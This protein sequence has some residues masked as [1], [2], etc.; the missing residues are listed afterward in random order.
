LAASLAIEFIRAS[1]VSPVTQALIDGLDHLAFAENADEDVEGWA[2][3]DWMV[4]GRIDGELV[5]QLGLLKRVIQV[6]GV[7]LVVGGVGGVATAPAWQ[8][9]GLST[10]LLRASGEF[11]QNELSVPFGLL[12]CGVEMQ[13]FYGRL[14]WQTIATELLFSLNNKSRHMDTIVMILPLSDQAW[15]EGEIDLCGSP[16]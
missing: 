1:L 6:G 13:R 5:T 3:P 2:D 8:R 7:K 14:G 4:L 16:W 9:Q 15:P 11:L 12:V 10:A